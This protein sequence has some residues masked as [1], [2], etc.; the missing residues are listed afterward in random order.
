MIEDKELGL[1]IAKDPREAKI[2]TLKERIKKEID[3]TEFQIEIN[4]VILEYLER[5]YPKKE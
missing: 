5:V 4:Q 1:K 2:E 3:D